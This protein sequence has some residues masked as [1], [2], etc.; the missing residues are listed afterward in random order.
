MQTRGDESGNVR[1]VHHQHGSHLARDGGEAWEIQSARVG[2]CPGQNEFRLML[3]GQALEFVIIDGL[4]L[5]AHSI[6]NNFVHLPGEIQRMT[7]GQVAAVRQTHAQQRVAGFQHG[8]IDGLIGLAAGVGLDVGVLGAEKFLGAL[9]GQILRYVHVL[10]TAV[11]ALARQ[12]LGILVGHHRPQGF[13]HR[14]AD[15]V[16]RGDQFHGARLAVNFQVDGAR[17][18]RVHFMERAQMRIEWCIHELFSL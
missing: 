6:R 13:Q 9:D 1:H 11:V 5:L 16:L 10:A 17:D 2:A 12:A 15:E 4:R 8:Q 18:F 14:L 3:L 7:M